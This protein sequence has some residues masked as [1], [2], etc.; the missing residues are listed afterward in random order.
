MVPQHPTLSYIPLILHLLFFFLALHGAC[1][2]GDCGGNCPGLLW[3]YYP[4][5]ITES[6]L[7]N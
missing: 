2:F 3:V 4:F 5:H 1:G 6:A 7:Y